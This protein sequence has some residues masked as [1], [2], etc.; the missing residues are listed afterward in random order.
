MKRFISF[1]ILFA[2]ASQFCITSSAESEFLYKDKY[3]SVYKYS[4]DYK[5]LY[6]HKD[7]NYDTDWVMIYVNG[8]PAD[9]EGVEYGIFGDIFYHD[10]T[11]CAP[12]EFNIGIYDVKNE[13][14][15]DLKKAWT[16]NFDDLHD[17]FFEVIT[18]A[19]I[20]DQFYIIGDIDNDGDLTI[21][22]ATVLQK[23]IAE[24]V[25]SKE[26]FSPYLYDYQIVDLYGPFIYSDRPS[27]TYYIK[28]YDYSY[29]GVCLWDYNSD[30]KL[31]IKD[32]TAIQKKL[33]K[34][35]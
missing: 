2:L 23:I 34:V 14:F 17:D 5:E 33:A 6:Y 24:I 8:Q 30:G 19:G 4:K 29:E 10:W 12:F 15:Y 11:P 32:A 25:N 27:F 20:N 1:I 13:Q 16:M 35:S 26:Y 31:N 9:V 21:K 28:E 3:K 7:K 22:D 18:T